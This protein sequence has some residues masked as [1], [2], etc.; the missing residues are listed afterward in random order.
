MPSGRHS[1]QS[2]WA[3]SW[4]G[5]G[6]A[7]CPPASWGLA[8]RLHSTF[9]V[10]RVFSLQT[11]SFF[12]K[13]KPLTGRAGG[14]FPLK[15]FKVFRVPLTSSVLHW[16]LFEASSWTGF[17]GPP[18]LFPMPLAWAEP[19]AAGLDSNPAGL[20]TCRGQAMARHTGPTENVRTLSCASSQPPSWLGCGDS[21]AGSRA[22]WVP[23]GHVGS[24]E[25]SSLQASLPARD[26]PVSRAPTLQDG[27]PD[28]QQCPQVV[29]PPM[30]P[31]G[32]LP[33]S[34]P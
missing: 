32:P 10:L 1:E 24:P 11:F 18:A 3:G 23:G 8:W 16:P 14:S 22:W 21:R 28:A 9:P 30:E 13:G 12:C 2:S 31:Q 34:Y 26:F 5:N 15:V 33:A 20:L 29:R 25:A 6:P 7:H 4:A 19:E 17:L 27:F